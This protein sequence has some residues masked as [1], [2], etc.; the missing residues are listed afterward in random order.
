MSFEILLEYIILLHLLL[1]ILHVLMHW[2]NKCMFHIFDVQVEMKVY[3]RRI[4]DIENV[5]DILL[6]DK[7]R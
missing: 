1:N 7:C 6:S 3:Y 2:D 4:N 5:H